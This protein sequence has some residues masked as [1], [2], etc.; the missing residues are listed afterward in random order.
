MDGMA[1]IHPVRYSTTL[2]AE[3]YDGSNLDVQ[4]VTAVEGGTVTRTLAEGD[5][6]LDVTVYP[7][8]DFPDLVVSLR[9]VVDGMLL[10]TDDQPGPGDLIVSIC[11]Q[12][13]VSFM[14][15]QVGV[16]DVNGQLTPAQFGY[17]FSQS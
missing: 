7:D 9:Q 13:D 16:I 8:G 2:T 4:V 5:V 14:A 6:V 12:D 3:N 1:T 15:G 11:P 10:L 17:L